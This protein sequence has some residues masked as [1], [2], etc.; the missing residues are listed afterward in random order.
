MFIHGLG[1]FDYGYR[2]MTAGLSGVLAPGYL[3]TCERDK[4]KITG[5]PW[6]RVKRKMS[7]KELPP[8]VFLKYTQRHGGWQWPYHF[9]APYVIAIFK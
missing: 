1:D 5:N 2:S 9:L 4:P 7:I 6:Q 8:R 3:G